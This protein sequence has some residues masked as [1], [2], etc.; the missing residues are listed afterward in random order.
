M[1]N[2]RTARIEAQT[3]ELSIYESHLNS[4]IAMNMNTNVDSLQKEILLDNLKHRYKQSL[5]G[6]YFSFFWHTVRSLLQYYWLFKT[7]R[8][9]KYIHHKRMNDDSL[10]FEVWN[11]VKF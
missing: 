4:H 1:Q 11:N 3:R 7:K 8:K 10:T 9:Q 2:T 5:T 6:N